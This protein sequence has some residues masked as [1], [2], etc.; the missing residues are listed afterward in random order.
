[1]AVRQAVSDLDSTVVMHELHLAIKRTFD[2][3]YKVAIPRG[4]SIFVGFNNSLAI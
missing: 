1:M 3:L 4:K 2:G